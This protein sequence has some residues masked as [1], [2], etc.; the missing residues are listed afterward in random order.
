MSHPGSPSLAHRLRHTF[1][2][3]RAFY[4][5]ILTL[6]IPLV[7]Q[8]LV[9]NFVN[10]LDNVMVGTLGT[11]ELSGVAIANQLIFVFNLS[12]FG[13]IAGAGIYGAQFAG[14]ADW[15]GLR[16][17]F[18]FKLLVATGITAIGMAVLY[19]LSDPLI[20]LYLTGE[21]DARDAADMLT[22][23]RTYLQ[24]MIWGLLPFAIT[25]SYSGTLRETGHATLP[26]IG[27]LAAVVVN[28][29]FNYLLIFGH[30]GFPRLG[31]QG[32]AIA[33]VM[34]RY[35]ELLVIA[36]WTHSHHLKYFFM[37]G[38]YRS[39]R[40]GRGLAFQI[41]TKSIPL[42]VN[43]FLWSVGMTTI[44]QILSTR[45]LVVMA[46]LNIASTIANLFNVFFLSMGVAVA[47]TVG[48]ALGANDIAKAKEQVWKIIFFVVC[49]C[50]VLGSALAISAN[51]IPAIYNTTAEVR[52]LA[53]VFMRTSALYM[54]FNAIAHCCYF[55]MRSGG[56][57]WIT[58]LF[59]SVYSW[60]IMVP[61][62]YLL[63][64]YTHLPVVLLFPLGHLPDA[65]KAILGAWVVRTGV[66]AKN[67]VG[68][69]ETAATGEAA[70]GG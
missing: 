53:T 47:V 6:A 67:I 43:E 57:T 19:F 12:I 27:S 66:W 48:Q 41:A 3:D 28:L 13:A 55:A 68:S 31:V 4:R 60:V 7:V 39:L 69:S 8:N 59:D 2:G 36:A 54:A 45:G 56:K 22:H 18:R 26:M 32:A 35:V 52:H 42:L 44:N 1:I 29:V 17:T 65:L 33:T 21:G 51:Y 16:Q 24:I 10:L 63:V 11:A 62:M 46:G 23:G 34:S 20:L 25:Q 40:I 50:V 61:C 49:I 38:V 64:H 15:E 5:V 58:F 14:A 30:F 9:S 70:A 37:E